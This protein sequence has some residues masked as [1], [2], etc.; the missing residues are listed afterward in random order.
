MGLVVLICSVLQRLNVPM[1]DTFI[2]DLQSSVEEA[3][4]NPS[5]K[6][7]MVSIYGP[8]PP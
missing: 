4:A 6:G 8:L 7:T 5:G 1:V 3:M 2:A